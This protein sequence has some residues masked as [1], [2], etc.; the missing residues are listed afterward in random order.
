MSQ[1]EKPSGSLRP[2]QLV[3]NLALVSVGGQVGCLTLLIVI[4]ALVAGLGLDR[5]LD[6]KPVFT[7]IFLLGSAPFSLYL[8]FWLAMRSIKRMT[9]MPPAEQTESKKEEINSE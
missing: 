2:E 8:T 7:L 4:V 6:T 1:T 9:P 3:P 5:W